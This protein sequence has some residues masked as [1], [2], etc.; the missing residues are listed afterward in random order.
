MPSVCFLNLSGVLGSGVSLL[1]RAV[2]DLLIDY[3]VVEEVPRT[4]RGTGRFPT[5]AL[6]QKGARLIDSDATADTLW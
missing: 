2:G 6:M 4:L 3:E 5:P 1:A